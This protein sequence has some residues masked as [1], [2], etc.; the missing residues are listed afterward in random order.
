MENVGASGD[1]APLHCAPATEALARRRLR[2]GSPAARRSSWGPILSGNLKEIPL[3][4]VLTLIGMERLTGVLC[5]SPGNNPKPGA[6]YYVYARSGRIVNAFP[7]DTAEMHALSGT[8][9]CLFR[10][11]ECGVGRFRFYRCQSMDVAA[12]VDR[13]VAGV[14]LDWA[15]RLDRPRRL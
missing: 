9:E 1:Q 4:A 12:N 13:S 2:R 6:R 15:A 5:V 14:L 3:S 7:S 10:A 8:D 11:L